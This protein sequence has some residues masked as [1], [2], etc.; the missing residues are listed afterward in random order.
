M[1]RSLVCSGTAI[2]LR[3]FC[4]TMLMCSR[5]AWSSCASRI[6]SDSF[7]LSTRSRTV[8]EIWKPSPCAARTLS[9]SPSS[10]I[11]TPRPAMT[12]FVDKIHDQRETAPPED[13]GRRTRVRRRS[14]PASAGCPASRW[15]CSDRPRLRSQDPV[16]AGDHGGGA[17]RE[18]LLVLDEHHGVLVGAGRARRIRWSGVP[19]KR[20]RPARTAWA[21]RCGRRSAAFRSCCP[22]PPPSIGRCGASDRQMLARKSDIVRVAQLVRAG[23]A[24]RDAVAIQGHGDGL[25]VQ[26]A[27]DQFA[28]ADL[29]RAGG[30]GL[31]VSLLYRTFVLSA[32][33]DWRPQ[34]LG[35]V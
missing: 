7:S 20:G 4:S 17:V 35:L 26:V 12:A 16:Q 13:G 32:L 1:T 9:W 5:R 11:R 15:S 19:P 6:S 30:Q 22:D 8:E 24:Q 23:A 25:A 2:M 10:V 18:L 3:T 31:S 27:D 14:E 28:G 21:F 34:G 33:Q 29:L